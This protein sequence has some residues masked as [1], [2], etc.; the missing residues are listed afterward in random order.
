MKETTPLYLKNRREWRAWLRKNHATSDGV[1]MLYYKKHTNKPRISY[2]DA[3]EE[4]LCYGWID[5]KVRRIDNEKFKQVYTPRNDNSVW[6]LLNRKR[7]LKMI[8]AGKMTKAGMKKI[9]EAKQNGK[10]QAAYTSRKKSRLPSDLKKALMKNKKAWQHFQAFAN[11]YQN[12]YIG[13]VRDS[14][15]KET[16]EKRIKK[17]VARSAQNKK[18]GVL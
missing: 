2:D 8:R 11:S 18:A 1:W 16:R 14:K 12:M 4:A 7:A 17:V 9:E 13:W 15:R 5:S 3:V 10:W 6:S